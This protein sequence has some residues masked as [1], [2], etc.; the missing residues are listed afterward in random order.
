GQGVRLDDV[1]EDQVPPHLLFGHRTHFGRELFPAVLGD[2]VR[3]GVDRQGAVHQGG[4]GHHGVR[5]DDLFDQRRA[6]VGVGLTVRFLL[7]IFTHRLA[8]RL[9]RV[10][11]ADFA[12]ERVVERRQLLPLH[13][14]ER[15]PHLARLAPFRFFGKVGG[16]LTVASTVSPGRR[17]MTF[18]ST[19][20]MARPSPRTNWYGWV[21]L[22]SSPSRWAR[23]ICTRSFGLGFSPAS[24]IHG[25]FWSRR[26]LICASTWSA[27]TFG[28]V[29]LSVNP[30]RRSSLR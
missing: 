3:L 25:A 20:G 18:S 16:N 7:Q 14:G 17:D 15:D 29:R 13:L 1:V 5:R 21:S 26:S 19:S 12:R 2:A 30:P 6:H 27:E 8:Q 11:V 24:G 28:T 22:I 23:V 4:G 9:H 10:E